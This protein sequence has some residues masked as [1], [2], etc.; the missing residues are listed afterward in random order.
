M[1]AYVFYSY[2]RAKGDLQLIHNHFSQHNKFWNSVVVTAVISGIAV[3][4]GFV[5]GLVA[6]NQFDI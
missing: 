4:E 6:M 3:L 2:E 5:I 1:T